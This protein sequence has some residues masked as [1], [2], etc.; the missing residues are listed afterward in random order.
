MTGNHSYN[1]MENVS[2][3]ANGVIMMTNKCWPTAPCNK[4]QNPN[5]LLKLQVHIILSVILNSHLC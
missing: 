2:E 3:I 4:T 1:V 5:L